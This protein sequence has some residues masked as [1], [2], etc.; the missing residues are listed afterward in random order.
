M[1]YFSTFV[2]RWRENVYVFVCYSIHAWVYVYVVPFI[3]NIYRYIIYIYIY[4]KSKNVKQ[5]L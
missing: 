2:C 1:K 4:K 3:Y 5:I